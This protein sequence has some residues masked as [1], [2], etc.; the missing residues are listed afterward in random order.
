MES[1][2]RL[3][4]FLRQ[5]IKINP[6]SV[7]FCGIIMYKKSIVGIGQDGSF[8]FFSS[9][10]IPPSSFLCLL[11]CGYY[12]ILLLYITGKKVFACIIYIDVAGTS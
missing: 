1:A 6:T 12:C 7:A 9:I 11:T 5:K 2:T 10:I 4:G 3:L 8:F